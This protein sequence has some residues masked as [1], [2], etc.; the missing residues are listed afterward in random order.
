M[1]GATLYAEL[2]QLLAW[3]VSAKPGGSWV[4]WALGAAVDPS[5]PAARQVAEWQAAQAIEESVGSRGAQTEWLIRKSLSRPPAAEGGGS[6]DVRPAA[7]MPG[8]DVE[9]RIERDDQLLALLISAGAKKQPMPSYAVL[10]SA[11]GLR[12]R[13]AARN[14]LLRLVRQGRVSI[15]RSGTARSIRL[16]ATGAV[17]VD[18]S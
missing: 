1:S 3:F 14:V 8:A 5:H 11:L 16:A 9:D 15:G 17:L 13:H 18:S 2:D 6:A 7:S 4:R 10:A 12:N